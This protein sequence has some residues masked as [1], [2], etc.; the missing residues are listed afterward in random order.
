MYF[1]VNDFSSVYVG[2]YHSPHV[3]EIYKYLFE[4]TNTTDIL[5]MK[6]QCILKISELFE[7]DMFPSNN[8]LEYRPEMSI[9]M[10]GYKLLQL[11]VCVITSEEYGTTRGYKLTRSYW[12]LKEGYKMQK[13]DNF[14]IHR[15]ILN[16]TLNESKRDV[17]YSPGDIVSYRGKNYCFKYKDF[18]L[19]VLEDNKGNE[20]KCMIGE[21]EEAIHTTV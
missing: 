17:N 3:R 10:Y 8:F 11:L 9:G 15:E 12:S 18:L 6:S 7:L 13:S 19:V 16:R 21:V 20:I 14:D 4:T 2:D 1:P 5:S